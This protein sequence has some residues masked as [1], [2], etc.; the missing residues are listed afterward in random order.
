MSY[1]PGP[2]SSQAY[3]LTSAPPSSLPARPPPSANRYPQSS[4]SGANYPA[5]YHPQPAY[6][7]YS[8]YGGTSAQTS[9]QPNPAFGG[10]SAPKTA[11]T[12]DAAHAAEIAQWNA[13]YASTGKPAVKSG[14]AAPYASAGFAQAV[15]KPIGPAIGAANDDEDAPAPIGPTVDVTVMRKGGLQKWEDK[16]L[17]EW[18]PNHPRLFVGNLAGEVTDDSLFKAFSR[19]PSLVKAR[20]VRDKRTTKSKGF[21]FVSFSNSEDYFNAFREMSGKYVGSHPIV[22]RKATSKVDRVSNSHAE[23]N[24]NNIKKKKKGLPVRPEEL[25]L[26]PELT[27]DAVIAQYDNYHK[28]KDV[29]PTNPSATETFD[30]DTDAAMEQHDHRS[31]VTDSKI[32]GRANTGAGVRKKKKGAKSRVQLLG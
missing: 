20:V 7:A 23:K 14:S 5:S 11:D 3:D 24:L 26:E 2:K 4:G 19:Y 18:D 12:F 21:G 15:P 22:L 25:D 10:Y 13:S 27:M 30:Q 29:G 6:G 31:T 17:L 32:A 16:S 8:G 9:Y 28:Q 1:R